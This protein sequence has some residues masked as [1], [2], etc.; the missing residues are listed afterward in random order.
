MRFCRSSQWSVALHFERWQIQGP[1]TW[2]KQRE[3]NW[4]CSR[5][6]VTGPRADGCH[7][8]M[9]I[10]GGATL[11]LHKGEE[12]EDTNAKTGFQCAVNEHTKGQA[13]ERGADLTSSRSNENEPCQLQQDNRGFTLDATGK[14]KLNLACDF[15][16][17]GICTAVRRHGTKGGEGTCPLMRR[18][19][20]PKSRQLQ[21]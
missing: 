11:L 7:Q 18:R 14:Y 20:R 6:V 2:E 13:A 17:A 8:L 3:N 19:L 21:R 5:Q 9:D 10:G 16:I 1:T 12:L 4:L 15:I